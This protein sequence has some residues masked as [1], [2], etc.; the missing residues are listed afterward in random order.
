[1][2]MRG[3]M[4]T[5]A[6]HAFF[7][8]S[9]LFLV[10]SPSW[11]QDD[12]GVAV[13]STRCVG[14][15]TLNAGKLDV[16]VSQR[17]TPEGWEMTLMRMVRTYGVQAQPEELRTL[18]K[19]LSD[20]YGLAPAEVEPFRYILEKRN[21]KVVSH[22]I[23]KFVT[24][25]CV[26]CH[27]YE[28]TALQRR[29]PEMW[30]RMPDMK[31]ALFTNTENV[32]ASSGLLKDYWF[33]DAKKVVV[34]YLAK[35][36]PLTTP[37]WTKWQAAPKKNFAGTWKVVGHD[38]G[39]GGDY[40]G[41]V[42]L[43]ALGGD[44]YEGDYTV[45]SSDGSKASGKTTGVI[46]TG[47]QW[48]GVMQIAG[49]QPQKEI[50]FANEAGTVITG[51]RL[52]TPVGDLGMDET[53][54]RDDGKAQVLSIVPATIQAGTTQKVK[55]FGLHLP[56]N[57]AAAAITLGAGVAVRSLTQTGDD[58]IV[59][60]VVAEDG[61][62]VGERQG[63]VEGADGTLPF[64]VYNNIDYIR[65]FPEQGFARPGG[66]RI[67]KAFQQFEAFAYL[68]G[69][70]RVKGTADDIK[71]HRV[72]PGKWNL[73]E[74]IK[75]LND[76]DM[77]FVGTVDEHG[78]FTPGKDGPNAQRHMIDHNVGD[79]WVEA[80]YTPPGA[81]RPMGARAYLLVMPEKFNFQPI[82]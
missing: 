19:H 36:F 42:T 16:V 33:D 28:R 14:C 48:R 40:T 75:R 77:H 81:K 80:W 37:E 66:E 52:L 82:D 44:K 57:L 63:K 71:L 8:W 49:G 10:L 72:N 20:H 34:P 64:Y 45:E 54:Y 7:L 69:N 56:Q 29:S 53:W 15:H 62:K 13:L 43:Q 41:Q 51:R 38:P 67:P 25:S 27:S 70:D 32:T 68:T 65:L 9:F 58:T 21:N 76:D 31:L 60:E 35:Q 74:Y 26:Q 46:Y 24:A 39:K 4:T 61:A 5:V 6:T 12:P 11:G 59:A 30:G 1:M 50:L 23:P 17:K 3:R 22:D 78:L 2:S 79:V 55:I 47:F 73:E 18:L